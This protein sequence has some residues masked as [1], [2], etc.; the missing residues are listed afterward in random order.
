MLTKPTVVI[1]VQPDADSTR[2]LTDYIGKNIDKINDFLVVKFIKV[3]PK[4]VQLV[5]ARGVE[6]TPTLVYNKKKYISVEKIISILTPP[7]NNQDHFGYGNT[8]SDDMVHAYH[9]AI[10]NTG[11]DDQDEDHP[12]MRSQVIKQ[13][14]VAFQKRRPEMHGVESGRK[15]KGGRKITSK[16]PPKSEFGN[17]AEFVKASR[18]DNVEST[19]F[20]RY[21]DDQDGDYL[22]EEYY[23]DE[24]NKSGKKVGK[25]VSKRR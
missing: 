18:K 6:R 22:L 12:D 17:D 14:M 10:L 9:D 2:V 20:K 8:S 24:A 15:V 1:Y 7:A 3:N 19:P 5:R 21:A 23:L 4:N 16:P 11:E 13:K 25:V